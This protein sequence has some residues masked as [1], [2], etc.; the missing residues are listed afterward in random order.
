MK[1]N[2]QMGA[3][4]TKAREAFLDWVAI[5][6]DQSGIKD[7]L[8]WRG[9][10]IWWATR[11][12]QKETFEDSAWFIEYINRL[13]GETPKQMKAR[14]TYIILASIAIST[15]Y[16][17]GIWFLLKLFLPRQRSERCAIWFHSL[18][19]NLISSIQGTYDRM[20]QKT[21]LDDEEHGQT[22]GYLI[23]LTMSKLLLTHPFRW[24]KNISSYSVSLMRPVHILDQFLALSDIFSVHANLFINYLKYC[25]IM[26]KNRTQ[27]I[28]VGKIHCTDII[29]FE[30]QQSF[31]RAL[32]WALVYAAMFDRW[33][34]KANRPQ[35]VVN[36]AE[37][38]A[39][40][41]AVQHFMARSPHKT[42]CVAVQHATIYR[43][44]MGLCHRFSEFNRV[45][46][47]DATEKSPKP[48][49]Y[50]VHG[51][52]SRDIIREFYPP[53][54]IIRI[55]CLKYD[56]LFAIRT[57]NDPKK[58]MASKKKNLERILLLAPSIGDEELMFRFLSSFRVLLGWRVVLS[59]HP[60]MQTENLKTLMAKLNI[61]L[62]IDIA[63]Q[64]STLDLISQSALVV[65]AFSSIALESVYL[66]VPAL[67]LVDLSRP[68]VVSGEQAIPMVST[69]AEFADILNNFS[70][71]KRKIM[72]PQ[73]IKKTIADFFFKIDGNVS[74]RFWESIQAIAKKELIAKQN[75]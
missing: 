14:P 2:A 11:L 63:E 59:K 40:F 22:A 48:D 49:Y 54:R 55:G 45:S 58:K 67:R 72:R 44:K 12:I 30:M 4:W 35:I 9:F 39:P 56:S 68:P 28:Y 26:K 37:T 24:R 27:G 70:R 41:R 19:Y 66:G 17:F 42:V 51:D 74:Q 47:N 50:L 34:K 8:H 5:W 23:R 75:S 65:T 21:P 33:Q 20:Y 43:D 62:Q 32:P 7:K 31:T 15:L 57:K 25:R 61:Q 1:R 10:P 16:Y 73:I 69:T 18:E 13:L 64:V 46:E 38:L 71:M 53:N 36:Y 52:Q 29:H 3:V 60:A 6:G